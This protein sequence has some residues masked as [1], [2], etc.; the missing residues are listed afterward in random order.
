[1]KTYTHD[2]E[3]HFVKILILPQKIAFLHPA[4]QKVFQSIFQ[5]KSYVRSNCTAAG[6]YS[7]N[8]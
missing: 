7:P 2:V 5:S 6:E 4:N 8:Y 3:L 1:M